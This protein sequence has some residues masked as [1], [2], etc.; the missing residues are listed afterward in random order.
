M[1]AED[2]AKYRQSARQVFELCKKHDIVMA[3]EAR[4]MPDVE[5][6]IRKVLEMEEN[7]PF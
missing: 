5:K 2:K 6:A 7:E 4:Q 1:T 3:H